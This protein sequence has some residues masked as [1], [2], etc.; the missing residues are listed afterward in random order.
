[1]NIMLGF[2]LKSPKNKGCGYRTI[3]GS[4]NLKPY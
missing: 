1:M 4:L 3:N 2:T